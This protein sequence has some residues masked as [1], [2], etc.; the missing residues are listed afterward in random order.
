MVRLRL[1]RCGK[2]NRPFYRIVAIDARTR[3]DG[4]SIEILGH[5]DPAI[6]VN[7]K[8]A[9]VVKERVSYWLSKG[10]Q[11]SNTVKRLLN[12]NNITVK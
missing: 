6:P 2:R 3:R 9:T 12:K 1:A 10:A 4:R 7:S 8:K 11:P 5:Y